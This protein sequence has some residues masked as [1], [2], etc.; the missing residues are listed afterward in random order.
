[1]GAESNAL[2]IIRNCYRTWKLTRASE[3]N[4]SHFLLLED[5]LVMGLHVL[6]AFTNCTIVPTLSFVVFP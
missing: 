4:D 2:I 6:Q 5:V 3:E 1:M